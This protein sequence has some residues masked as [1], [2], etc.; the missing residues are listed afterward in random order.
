MQIREQ[1]S[2]EELKEFTRR[3]DLAGVLDPLRNTRTT[4]GRG[5]ERLTIAPNHANYHLEHHLL[6]SVP[7]HRLADLHRCLQARGVYEG[8][9]IVNGYGA[10]I[11]RLAAEPK[12]T[13]TS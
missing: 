9:E 5:W 2:A 8:A 13:S 10:V 3:S 12:T 6:P 4:I 11:A 7:P 1:L